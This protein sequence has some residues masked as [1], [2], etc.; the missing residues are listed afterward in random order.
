MRQMN[1]PSDS[2]ERFRELMLYIASKSEGDRNF[3]ATKLNKLLWLLDFTTYSVLGKPITG[4]EYQREK[5]GPVPRRLVP[6]REELI[7]EKAA[8]IQIRF[9]D[10]GYEQHRLVALRQ[11][12]LTMFSALEISCVDD[13]IQRFKNLTA[14]DMS[15]ASHE[16]VGWEIVDPGETIPYETVFVR[17]RQLTAREKEYARNLE[18]TKIA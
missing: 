15:E 4:Q 2:E 1:V 10:R 13:F 5:N 14:A 12:K 11:A 18:P 8:A 7:R 6:I 3:G 17:R 9:T 16:F